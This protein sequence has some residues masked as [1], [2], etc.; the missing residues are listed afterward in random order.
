M[1]KDDRVIQTSGKEPII[2]VVNMGDFSVDIMLRIWTKTDD[3][4]KAQWDLNKAIKEALDANGIDI[5][6]PTQLEIVREEKAG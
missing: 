5:P 1:E 3:Y 2:K 6:F 4:F